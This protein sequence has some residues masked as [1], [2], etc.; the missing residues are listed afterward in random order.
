[1][2]TDHARRMQELYRREA[3]TFDLTRLPV[4]LGRHR[5]P[6]LVPDAARVLEVGCGT[7]GNLRRLSAAAG[8]LGKVIGLECAPAMW[9]RARR[10]EGQGI[11]VL[12]GDY[13]ADFAGTPPPDVVVFSYSLSMMPDYRAALEHAWQSLPRGGR[14]VVLDFLNTGFE[15]LRRRFARYGVELGEARRAWLRSRGEVIE[16]TELRAWGGLWTYYLIAV[17]R[18]G[19]TAP[20]ARRSG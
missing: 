14:V 1:L 10:L 6:R 12:L 16:D 9:S 3:F 19:S 15:L 17:A 18:P 20:A 13:L 2:L 5:L 11:Q 4:L 7:G 8:P